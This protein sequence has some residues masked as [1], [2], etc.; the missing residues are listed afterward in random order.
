VVQTRRI[1]PR[2]ESPPRQRL[3]PLPAAIQRPFQPYLRYCEIVQAPGEL[4]EDMGQLHC[5]RYHMSLGPAELAPDLR[6][7]VL[8]C[9]QV[10]QGG[11]GDANCTVRW[12]LCQT[13]QGNQMLLEDNCQV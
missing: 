13:V 3:N 10:C 8:V 9:G 1:I 6:D 12:G 7:A 5:L 4:H 11:H 2:I